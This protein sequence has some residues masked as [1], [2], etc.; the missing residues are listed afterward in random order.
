MSERSEQIVAAAYDLLASEG[1]EGLTIRS[2]LTRTG[3]ARRAFY[4]RFATKDDL[5]LAVFEQ[6][7]SDAARHFS[8]LVSDIDDPME[9]LRLIVTSIALGTVATDDAS[10]GRH[11]RAAALAREHLRLAEARATDLHRAITPILAVIRD[12]LRAGMAA[13]VMRDADEDRLALLVYNLVSNTMHGQLIAE[14]RG[15]PNLAER[16]RLAEEIWEFCRR[17]VAR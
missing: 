13:G 4:D 3:L 1:L 8:R 16:T 9:R 6:S 11:R 12:Q 10:P 2:V 14:E 17:A 5:V 15:E 7:L